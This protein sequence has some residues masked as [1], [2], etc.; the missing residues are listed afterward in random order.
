RRSR[1]PARPQTTA[2]TTNAARAGPR[3]AGKWVGQPA[4]FFTTSP[5]ATNGNAHAHETAYAKTTKDTSGER[6]M[7]PVIGSAYS[8]RLVS[9]PAICARGVLGRRRSAAG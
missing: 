8:S 7:A 1:T 5:V 3:S 4:P 9:E 2:V 6:L